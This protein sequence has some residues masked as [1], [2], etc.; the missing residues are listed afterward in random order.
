MRH[1]V[2]QIFLYQR[3]EHNL[4]TDENIANLS[5]LTQAFCSLLSKHFW[6]KIEGIG[7]IHAVVSFV[8]VVWSRHTTPYIPLWRESAL[9][10]EAK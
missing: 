6:A 1:F 5:E 7:A 4:R 2:Y 9:T 3:K 10:D 8:A